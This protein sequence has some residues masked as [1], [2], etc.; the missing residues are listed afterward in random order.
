M[1]CE[2][3][4]PFGTLA[5]VTKEFEVQLDCLHIYL[6]LKVRPSW[7]YLVHFKTGLSLQAVLFHKIGLT[8]LCPHGQLKIVIQMSVLKKKRTLKLPLCEQWSKNLGREFIWKNIFIFSSHEK[9]WMGSSG[10]LA[11]GDYSFTPSMFL[12][13]GKYLE[14]EKSGKIFNK[15][16]GNPIWRIRRKKHSMGAVASWQLVIIHSRPLISPHTHCTDCNNLSWFVHSK[17]RPHKN[18]NLW[19][20]ICWADRNGP[21]KTVTAWRFIWVRLSSSG[22]RIEAVSK[23]F[24]DWFLSCQ[25]RVAISIWCL[26]YERPLG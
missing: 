24:Q 12:F 8:S 3:M 20:S 10:I 7:L 1:I 17:R 26:P 9:R 11:L 2:S 21:K 6:R 5:P 13:L 19:R 18:R 23:L 15:I 16:F 25:N 4:W 14:R 22:A